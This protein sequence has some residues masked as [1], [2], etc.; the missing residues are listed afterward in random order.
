MAG[1]IF[2]LNSIE[3]LEKC[4]TTGI[5][6]TLIKSPTKSWP[7]Y[8]KA[9]FADYFSM[10]EGDNVYFFHKRNIFGVGTLKNINFDCKFKNFPDAL[11]PIDY[12][13]S[14]ISDYNIL[15]IEELKLDKNKIIKNTN[16]CI[17]TFIPNP[18]FFKLGIDMDDVLSSNP[19]SFRMLRAFEKLSFVKIDDQENKALKDIILK[20]NEDFINSNDSNHIYTFDNT[21]HNNISNNIDYRYRIENIDIVKHCVNKRKNPTGK[22]TSEMAIESYLVHELSNNNNSIFGNWDYVSHQVIASPFKPIIYIDKMDIFG[23]KYIPGFDTISKYL[24][25][26]IKKDEAS[27]DTINQVMKYVDWISHEYSFGDYSMIEAFIVAYDFPDDVINYAKEI[28]KRT[29]VKV[30]KPYKS[31]TWNKIKLIKYCYDDDNNTMIFT[32]IPIF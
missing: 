1:Y 32:E 20:R 31:D 13:S 7:D 4:I 25:I 17:C 18:N 21:I 16:R 12:D 24:T 15:P 6:S 28:C 23:Y 8:A 5:Y 14:D 27:T 29:Y 2:N 30:R 11:N 22:I 19:Y 9:T 10:K 26:E 3:S